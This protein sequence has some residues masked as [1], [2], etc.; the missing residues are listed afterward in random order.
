M[1]SLKDSL[2]DHKKTVTMSATQINFL[3][4]LQKRSQL[5]LD[6]L[7]EILASEYLHYLAI[8]EFGMDPG[9]D[10]GFEYHPEKEYDNLVITEKIIGKK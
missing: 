8:S 5:A 2:A 7:M 4:R 3:T 10:F 1:D 6:Q 9:R